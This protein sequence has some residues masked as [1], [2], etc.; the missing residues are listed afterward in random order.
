MGTGWKE[1]TRG[2]RRQRGG[3]MS[4]VWREESLQKQENEKHVYCFFFSSSSNRAGRQ[5]DLSGR[6]GGTIS[7]EDVN[8]KEKC[9]FATRWKI[10]ETGQQLGSGPC[11]RRLQSSGTW[12]FNLNALEKGPS[13][14]NQ[15]HQKLATPTHSRPDGDRQS[16]RTTAQPS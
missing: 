13:T 3:W 8:H 12:G 16:N 11:C 2:R 4:G 7:T 10:K 5:R 6:W 9:I 14:L 1:R 15:P